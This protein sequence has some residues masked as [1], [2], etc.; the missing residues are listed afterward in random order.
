MLASDRS[1]SVV[2]RRLRLE[3]RWD[4]ARTERVG[5]AAF[6]PG[7]ASFAVIVHRRG[8]SPSSEVL[9]VDESAAGPRARSVF[10]GPGTFTSLAPSPDGRHL[11]VA[12]READQWLFIPVAGRARVTAVD[13]ISQQFSPGAEHPS[14]P[15]VGIS[16]WCC[17]R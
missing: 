14:F 12:W 1:V 10:A 8:A 13:Q 15:R 2:D 7:R 17:P 4:S 6:V 5:A 16:D 11:L 9:V 3:M